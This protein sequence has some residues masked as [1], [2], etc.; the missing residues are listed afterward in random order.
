MNFMSQTKV[1][2]IVV[3][4]NG[5]QWVEKCLTS[6]RE[7]TQPVHTIVIDNASTDDTARIICEKFPEVELILSKENLGFGRANNIGLKKALYEEADY[8]VLL[9]QDAWVEPE[10]IE[11]IIHI[12]QENSEYS[13]LS[14]VHYKNENEVEPYFKSLVSEENMAESFHEWNWGDPKK[15][16]FSVGFVHAAFWVITKEC[17][18]KVGFFD[19]IFPHYGED[20]DYCDRAKFFNF[21]IGIVPSVKITHDIG[22]RALQPFNAYFRRLC[23]LKQLKKLDIPFYSQFN[24]LIISKIKIAF[25]SLL[26][27]KFHKCFTLLKDLVFL[28]RKK[29]KLISHRQISLKGGRFLF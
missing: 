1:F 14:A 2:A 28:Y 20:E 10:T 26:V 21:S 5:S 19:P 9:N 23:Y 16:V 15:T 18:E 29:K 3:T 11:K 12:Q 7:S 27:L 24:Y 8:V 13:I 17:L 25:G 22:K 6:L 4:Y